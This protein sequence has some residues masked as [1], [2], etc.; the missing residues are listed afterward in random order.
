M[1]KYE[2][3]EKII[4][5]AIVNHCTKNRYNRMKKFILS[6][7]CALSVV[8]AS[9]ADFFSN[10]RPDNFLTVGARLGVNTTNRTLKDGAVPYSE[11]RE[12]WGTGFDIGAVA[13]IRIRDFISVQPGFFFE[14]RSGSYTLMRD[15]FLPGPDETIYS[16]QQAQMGKRH[17]WNFTIPILAVVSFNVTDNLRWNVEAGPYVSF[18]L[19]SELSST[20]YFLGGYGNEPIFNQKAATVDFGFKLGTSFDLFNNYYLGVH[21]M[22]GCVPAWKDKSVGNYHQDFGGVTKG[23]IFSIGYNFKL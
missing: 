13:D 19:G 8:G 22:A 3:V 9:A 23:W 20:R 1:I 14:S 5:F 16:I 11:H 4:K 6:A 15:V 10:T 21:Y 7:L 12:N 2:N 18:V 17:S